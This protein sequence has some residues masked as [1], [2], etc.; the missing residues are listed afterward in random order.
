MGEGQPEGVLASCTPA[1]AEAGA[2]CQCGS[3]ALVGIWG[4][5]GGE[6]ALM[7]GI[8]NACGM[9]AGEICRGYPSAAILA[10]GFGSMVRSAGLSERSGCVHTSHSH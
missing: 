10:L 9:K 5:E 7:P 3:Q 8:M 4:G 2:G 1:A 6:G